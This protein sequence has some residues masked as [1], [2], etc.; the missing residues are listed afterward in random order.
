MQDVVRIGLIFDALRRG[1]TVRYGSHRSQ[2]ADLH[3]PAAEGSPPPVMILIHGGSWRARYGRVV[4]R[5]L[6]G[7]LLARGWAVW[8]VEFRRIG[9]GGGWPATFLDVAAAIDRLA[10]LEE[11]VDLDRV[12]VL[13]HS[14]G[15]HLALWAASRERLP[16]GAPGWIGGEP[17]VRLRRA[18]AQAGVCDLTYAY[19][20]APDGSPGA[21]M[22]GGPDS[23]PDRYDAADPMRLLPASAP[24][25]LVHGTDD[26]TVPVEHSRRYERAARASGGEVELVEIPGEAGTHRAHIDPHEQAWTA[27]T[28]RLDAARSPARLLARDS[29][30]AVSGGDG[31]DGL[32]HR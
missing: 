15:G 2:R 32:A 17:R 6:A 22:G 29:T 24:V 3:M 8:N 19:Q 30:A 10:E 7:D 27:V 20:C 26:R 1:R 14:A 23:L 11:T 21:L 31:T 5:A 18:I 28:S 12:S 9:N 16:E 13:G 25:L 4:M